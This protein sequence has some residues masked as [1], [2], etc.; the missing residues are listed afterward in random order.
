MTLAG[1]RGLLLRRRAA[2][3]GRGVEGDAQ[4]CSSASTPPTRCTSSAAETDL[5]LSLRGRNG[6]G[7]RRPREHA[8]R[9]VLLLAARGLGRR[10]DLLRRADRA[11]RR[12]RSTG[13]RLTFREGR[14]EEAS[15][16]QGED[17]L[18]A[19]LDMDDGARF[20][21]ELGIGCNAGITK[22]MRNILYDEKMAG[23][24]HVAVG[25]S[26][27]KVGGTNVS[28][29]HW[30]LVKD[31]RSD[32][33][34]EL[35]GEVVQEDGDW[36]T[37][38]REVERLADRAP[39]LPRRGDDRLP[40]PRS[41]RLASRSA[42]DRASRRSGTRRDWAAFDLVVLR[43]PGTTRSGATHSSPG[44]A[45]L[46]R[47]L[48][49]ARGARVEHRQAALPGRPRRRGRAD[50]PDRVRRARAV[51]STRPGE[52]FVD[53]A[54]DLGGRPEL[55]AG[56]SPSETEAAAAL[57]ARIHAEGRTA[58]VQPYL[59]RPSEKALVYLGRQVLAT[60]SA[61]ASRSRR[62]ASARSSTSTS[63]SPRRGHARRARPSPTRRSPARP[64]SCSTP[65]ST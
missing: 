23:T 58:M 10:D 52:P 9:R 31:L 59:A 38:L 8:R 47:V 22:P 54:G 56:S 15:A 41:T 50:R 48:N 46:P 35:D 11:R 12:R 1:V 29:L 51:A 32:G 34:I 27:P 33:R 42:L 61:A 39:R 36:L 60:L 55:G 45:S 25:A 7:R 28:A 63:S 20:V 65:A 21:G 6:R 44:H 49:P 53:Q 3:L 13:I 62:R 14:V 30:D 64:A 26:Y 19:A 2:R 57:A 37:R 24:I 17:A 43:S 40:R 16:E 18:L 5:T 4:R